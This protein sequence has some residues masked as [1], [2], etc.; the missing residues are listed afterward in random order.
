LFFVD[1]ESILPYLRDCFKE[2]LTPVNI[3]ITVIKLTSFLSEGFPA[4][5]LYQTRGELPW[6]NEEAKLLAMVVH[7]QSRYSKSYGEYNK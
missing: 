3:P 6:I 5:R 1:H 4:F 7:A 2:I